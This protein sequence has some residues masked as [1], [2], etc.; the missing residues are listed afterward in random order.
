MWS[1][2]SWSLRINKRLT[3]RAQAT[4]LPAPYRVAFVV[5]QH[6]RHVALHHIAGG[7]EICSYSYS[8]SFVDS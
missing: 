8:Y 3:Y 6:K 2:P 4:A 1:P 7:D 5:T